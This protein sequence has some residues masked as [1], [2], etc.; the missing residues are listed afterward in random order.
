LQCVLQRMLQCV[1]AA[2][3]VAMGN[4]TLSVIVGECGLSSG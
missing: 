3:C 1:C 4:R 2:V